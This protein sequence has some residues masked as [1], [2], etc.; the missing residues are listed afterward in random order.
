M[1]P[2]SAKG[3]LGEVRLGGKNDPLR[4]VQEIEK[5][6]YYQLVYAQTRICP[7]EWHS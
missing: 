4:I 6:S 5:R 3:I 7:G 2:T 1:K